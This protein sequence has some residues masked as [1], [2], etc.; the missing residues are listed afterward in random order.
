M[1]EP[2]SFGSRPKQ[3][4]LPGHHQMDKEPVPALER[5]PE[6][7]SATVDPLESFPGNQPCELLRQKFT[8]DAGKS[9]K[10][11]DSMVAPMT[12]SDIERRTV[13]TSGSSG[14][15]IA[16]CGGRKGRSKRPRKS[17]I[18]LSPSIFQDL[19]RIFTKLCRDSR[20]EPPSPRAFEHSPQVSS[21]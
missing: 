20:D 19:H 8:D 17:Q 16:R 11:T 12:R 6:M 13:S 5:E 7:L 18:C 15:G 1:L 9:R 4:K 21:Q 2:R 10:V 14:M 3:Q